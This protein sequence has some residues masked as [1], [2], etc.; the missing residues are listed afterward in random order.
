MT[1]P[2]WITIGQTLLQVSSF[3]ALMLIVGRR[4]LPWV[5]WQVSRTGSRELFTL[6]VVAVAIGIAY[7]AAQV[8]SVPFA[9]GA[10]FA[11]M[12]M[13]ESEFS[14]RAAQ[15]SLPLRDAFSVLF[16]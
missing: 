7:G 8:F 16:L 2:L 11:G 15:E 10:F 1:K 3:L 4:V 6:S 12:V 14:H 9:L 13:R 5:L